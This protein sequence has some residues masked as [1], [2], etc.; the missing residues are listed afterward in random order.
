M[1]KLVP[2]YSARE[3]ENGVAERIVQVQLLNVEIRFVSFLGFLEELWGIL[4][5]FSVEAH[6]SGMQKVSSLDAKQ[7]HY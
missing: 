7:H 2:A 3:F 4:G 5:D 1:T 6:I